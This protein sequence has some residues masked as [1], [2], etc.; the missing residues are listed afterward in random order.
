MADKQVEEAQSEGGRR[1][2]EVPSG[3]ALGANRECLEA[4]KNPNRLQAVASSCKRTWTLSANLA[5]LPPVL[6]HTLKFVDNTETISTET[7]HSS[8]ETGIVFQVQKKKE[9][10]IYTWGMMDCKFKPSHTYSRITLLV[11]EVTLREERE[12]HL[13]KWRGF[14]FLGVL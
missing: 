3:A 5:L 7:S 13:L 11:S 2:R 4:L 14:V 1:V 6:L 12:R 8:E 10:S 9:G